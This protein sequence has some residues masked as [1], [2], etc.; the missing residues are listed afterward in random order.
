M[1]QRICIANASGYRWLDIVPIVTI[2]SAGA[3]E[4]SWIGSHFTGK[5]SSASFVTNV[6]SSIFV[7][8]RHPFSDENDQ[9]PDTPDR[10]IRAI[11]V[12]ATKH[13]VA[14]ALDFTDGTSTSWHGGDHGDIHEFVLEAGENI[15]QVWRVANEQRILGLSFGTSKGMFIICAG[16]NPLLTPCQNA[17][18]PGTAPQ[19]LASK[20]LSGSTR[21]MPSRALR[22]L[23]EMQY[24]GSWY[25]LSFICMAHFIKSLL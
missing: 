13:I 6:G 19:A 10:I 17:R 3:Q 23:L 14:I 18:L 7:L 2:R 1:Y 24:S 8:T 5:Y 9:D 4:G 21:D 20:F 12:K 22:E 16:Y 15:H 11:R 25:Y